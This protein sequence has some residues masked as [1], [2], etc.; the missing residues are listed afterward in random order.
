MKRQEKIDEAVAFLQK[1]FSNK[2]KVGE[3][4]NLHFVAEGLLDKMDFLSTVKESK[5]RNISEAIST[6]GKMIDDLDR[7]MDNE[8]EQLGD[9]ERLLKNFVRG[10]KTACEKL[11]Y[12]LEEL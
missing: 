9:N 4:V 1:A 10:Q 6:F 5:S 8:L 11:K 12:N 3:E 7:D 2:I